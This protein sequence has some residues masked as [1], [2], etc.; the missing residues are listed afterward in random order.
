MQAPDQQLL[1]RAM[2]LEAQHILSLELVS[3]SGEPLAP[4]SAGAHVDLHLP[5]GLVRSYSLTNP[6]TCRDKYMLAVYREPQSK[7]GSHFVHTG[8]RVGEMLT[9]S[10]PRDLF[11]V[12]DD[13]K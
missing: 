5:G 8:L 13:G 12:A 11:S 1:V 10:G 2:R 6:D 3:P 7:G 9:V 4:F